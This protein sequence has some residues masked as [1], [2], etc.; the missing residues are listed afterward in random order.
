MS[1]VMPDKDEFPIP[2]EDVILLAERILEAVRSGEVQGIAVGTFYAD[3]RGWSKSAGALNYVLA[4]HLEQERLRVL[5]YLSW[6][7][8]DA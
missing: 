8:D 5:Q 2:Q 1:P 3:G 4:G 6:Y 7:G